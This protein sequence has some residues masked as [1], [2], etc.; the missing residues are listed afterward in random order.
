MSLRVRPKA[1]YTCTR[2][3]PRRALERRTS[4]STDPTRYTERTGSG[5]RGGS[6]SVLRSCSLGCTG[7]SRHSCKFVYHHELLSSES[8]SSAGEVA[9]LVSAWS[10]WVASGLWLACGLL[11]AWLV[12]VS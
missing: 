1:G 5:C 9:W 8:E 7:S 12:F 10:A 11:E 4:Q 6:R 2:H 3:R